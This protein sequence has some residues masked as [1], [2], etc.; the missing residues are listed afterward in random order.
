MEISLDNPGFQV[1]ITDAEVHHSDPPKS[2]GSSSSS[3]DSTRRSCI[4]CHGRMSSFSLDKHLF[5]TKCRGREC[6]L[7]SRC[8]ECIQWT[9]EEMESY[10]KLR[11]SLSSKGRRNKTSSSASS[12]PRSMPHDSDFDHNLAAQIDSVNKSVDQKLDAMS[13]SLISK[14]SSMLERFQLGLNPQSFPEDSAVLGYS[15]C[16]S[17][18]L[19]L[20]PSVST[21]SR[22]GFWFREG[23]EDPVPHES[24][25][26]QGTASARDSL[27]ETP[28]TFQ[29]PLSGDTGKPQGGSQ[30]APGYS[31]ENQS[32]A[33]FESQHEEDD[34]DDKDSV[35]ELPPLDKTYAR[36]V[37]HIYDR[38][39]HSRPASAPRLPQWCEFENFFA[40]SD[41]TPASRQNLLL[42]PRVSELVDSSADRASRLARES[43]PLQRVVPL[44]RKMFHIGD[45]PDY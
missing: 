4:K 11:K 6:S 27:D 13:S 41:S 21:K 28:E 26:T 35:V 12:P 18:P 2:S 33:G 44:K 38:F 15:A 24:G 17:E 42:Y 20:H 5:C 29:H 40:I 14:F 1:D 10:V 9:K 16:L 3:G 23:G 32:G 25:L 34:E 7:M 22:T 30:R 8:D 45:Q 36:L 37:E 43:R 19:S 39:P 31:G